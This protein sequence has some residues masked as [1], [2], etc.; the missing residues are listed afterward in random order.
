[1]CKVGGGE[2]N[3]G[4]AP[5]CVFFVKDGLRALFYICLWTHA[6]WRHEQTLLRLFERLLLC[7]ALFAGW[8]IVPRGAKLSISQIFC[9][10]TI[11]VLFTSTSVRGAGL[12]SQFNPPL[13]K[14]SA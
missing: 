9:L 12:G 4:V 1:M 14:Q 7:N 8:E 13:H 10:R 2:G 11:R 6:G 5:T 3:S